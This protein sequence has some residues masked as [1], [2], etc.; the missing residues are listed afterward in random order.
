MDWLENELQDFDDDYLI[1]DCPGTLHP[2]N[3]PGQIE[4][5]THIPVMKDIVKT[6][7]R[8]N[9][10]I[11]GVYLLDSQF[12]QDAS[13][14]F[15]GVMTAMSA[16]VQ[17]EIPHINVLT[18]MD[19]LGD[20]AQTRR[21]ERYL[22]ADPSLL[23][24]ELNAQTPSKFDEL[25]RALLRLIDEYSLVSFIPLNIQDED[26]IQLVLSHIDHAMQV[27]ILFMKFTIVIVRR[28]C[29]AHGTQG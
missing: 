16:M 9:Y 2:L 26:S 13:K 27:C 28:G 20:Q 24:Q 18:K 15:S 23:L 19:L 17:L 21:I 6:L 8:L 10:R 14:F 5:Y 25:N 22:E 3:T 7:E 12:V 11:C 4:L 1:F 29:R